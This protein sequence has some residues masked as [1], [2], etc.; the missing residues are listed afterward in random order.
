MLYNSIIDFFHLS[1]QRLTVL[2]L[3]VVGCF[4]ILSCSDDGPSGPVPVIESFSP[5]SGE[6]GVM[7]TITGSNFSETSADVQ[8]Y[9]N[10]VAGEV[11]SSTLTQINVEVP[12]GATTGRITVKAKGVPGASGED[13]KVVVNP[14]VQKKGFAY[15][16]GR[17]N[18]IGFAFGNKGYIGLGTT[19]FDPNFKDLWMYDPSTDTWTQKADFGG[20]GRSG[21][22]S[23]VIGSKVYV[24]TGYDDNGNEL[25]DFWEYDPTQNTWIQKAD[26]AGVAR[27]DAASFVIGDKGYVGCGYYPALKDFWEYNPSTNAWTQK[28]DFAG[29]ARYDAVG[30]SINSKGY[31]GTGYTGG[32][33]EK[34]FWEYD[35][36]SDV[37]AKKADFGGSTRFSAVAFVVNGFAYV[38]TGYL[39]GWGNEGEKDFW[40]YDPAANAWTRV[41]DFFGGKS[42]GHDYGQ[43]GRAVAF[44]IGTKA[45]VGTGEGGLFDNTDF[46]EYTPE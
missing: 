7:V 15:N 27:A 1:T 23:M 12:E 21:A 45:Y 22:V 44:T 46:W 2:S 3:I 25:K 40:K 43:R 38:G 31:I 11:I 29:T 28:A 10:G 32:A 36:A 26:F 18:A 37:W 34:D 39:T 42:F 20:V 9:F 8:V 24:G 16:L 30:F 33:A 14:W 4:S 41:T 6:V 35:P 19:A 17:E 5:A 13:F